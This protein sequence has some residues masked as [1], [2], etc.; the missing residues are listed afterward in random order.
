MNGYYKHLAMLQILLSEKQ[1]EILCIQETHFKNEYFH[2]LRGYQCFHKNRTNRDHA[3]GG[4][5]I[6]VSDA[7]VVDIIHLNTQMEVVA[8]KVS[9]KRIINVCNF[10]IPDG[11]INIQD[12]CSVIDQVPPPRIILGDFNGHNII[13]GSDSTDNRGQIIANIID[14]YNFCLLNDGSCS[15][16]ARVIQRDLDQAEI[17][18]Q[19][20]EIYCRANLEA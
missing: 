13:W 1:P 12:I 8:T 18:K 3:S 9:G 14:L 17:S 5:A 16:F 15:V 20:E 10:Y 19:V 4:V 11:P 2:Q 6:Y 7:L